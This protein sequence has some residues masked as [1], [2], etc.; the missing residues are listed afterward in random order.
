MKSEIVKIGKVRI[1]GGLPIIIQSMTDTP[2]SDVTATVKQCIELY[3]AGAEIVR[4]TVNDD[5]S[6]KAVPEIRKSLDKKGYKDIA[7]IGDF[8]F[9]GHI[10]LNKY[11][12]LVKAL[13]KFRVNPA[14]EKS[15]E[16]FIR[17]AAENNKTVRIGLNKGSFDGDIVKAILSYAAKAEK[18]GLKRNQIVLSLK[19]SDAVDFIKDH[20]RL[21][22]GM[23]KNKK[24]Y[25]L[26]VG[27]TEAGTGV[28][29]IVASS[30]ATG[31]LLQKGI[32]DTIR[33]SITPTKNESRTKE[34]E[35]C[36][37][38]LQTLNIRTFTPKITSCPGCGRTNKKY[39]Q[40]MVERINEHIKKYKNAKNLHIAIMGCIVNGPGECKKADI[41]IMLP[42]YQEKQT[43]QVYI[44]G[45]LTKSLSGKNMLKEFF[46]ILDKE[47]KIS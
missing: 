31:I 47:L 42:G 40:E 5:T 39:F 37:N 36:K 23:K 17:I 28:Q 6:A 9:N 21:A 10:L 18:L 3:D 29:G 34:V 19:S 8:H 22:E 33:V 45:K 14:N 11:P 1:G 24:I 35:V 30:V 25:A 41:A 16:E 15:F 44:K 27:L 26:H 4:M 46:E 7:L 13:D 43:A 32:G 2:T 20:E 38:I 12:L